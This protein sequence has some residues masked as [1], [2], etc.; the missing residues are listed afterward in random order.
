METVE[1]GNVFEASLT[2]DGKK[3]RFLELRDYYY[4]EYLDKEQMLELIYSLQVLADKI[5]D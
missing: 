1:V 3:V 2:E 5:E 4:K